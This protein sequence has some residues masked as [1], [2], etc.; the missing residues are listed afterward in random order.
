[1]FESSFLSADDPLGEHQIFWATIFMV[2]ISSEEAR[3]KMRLKNISQRLDG[4]LGWYLWLKDQPG[5]YSLEVGEASSGAVPGE[6]SSRC[7][8]KYYP[9]LTGD[10]AF[11]GLSSCEKAMRAGPLFDKTGTPSFEAAASILR[12][13]FIV[14]YLD[15][16]LTETYAT[17]CLLAQDLWLVMEKKAVDDAEPQASRPST[18]RCLPGWELAWPVANALIM[19]WCMFFVCRPLAAALTQGPGEFW[20]YSD[21]EMRKIFSNERL[22]RELFCFLPRPEGMGGLDAF[23][24][25]EEWLMERNVSQDLVWMLVQPPDEDLPWANSDWWRVSQALGDVGLCCL[26]DNAV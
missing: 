1:M 19:A 26:A 24:G 14:G 22:R 23:G 8:I 17:L 20:E 18:A 6:S 2:L 11:Q 5:A 4:E 15:L 16:R 9:A 21:G 10:P 3:D 13:A 25:V 12:E 7:W